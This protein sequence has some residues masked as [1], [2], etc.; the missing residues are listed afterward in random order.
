MVDLPDYAVLI[1]GLA[2][3]NARSCDPVHEPRLEKLVR[4][5]TGAARVVLR[6]PLKEVDALRNISGSIKALRFSEWSVVHK[7]IPDR[8]AFGITCRARLLVHYDDSCI[9]DWKVYKDEDGEHRLVPVRF[10]MACPHGHLSDIRWRDFCFE[11]F[12][13]KNSERLYLLEAGTGNDFTQ[14]TTSRRSTC[15]PNPARR[16]SWPMP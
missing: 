16:A 9:K 6:T 7:K 13:C 5:A 2:F 3:W 15:R 14:A 4:Q 11:Q 10:V 12:N 1:G 8:V